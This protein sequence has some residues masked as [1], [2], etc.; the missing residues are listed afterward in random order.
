[1][2]RLHSNTR[3]A[4]LAQALPDLPLVRG[5][6]DRADSGPS[7]TAQRRDRP[8]PQGPGRLDGHGAQ[9]AAAAR[10]GEGADGAAAPWWGCAFGLR[11]PDIGETP[12][13]VEEV[14]HAVFIGVAMDDD[15]ELDTWP[16]KR[17]V[18]PAGTWT[19]AHAGRPPARPFDVKFLGSK[20]A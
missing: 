19:P 13:S 15:D 5:A 8:L 9:R 1:M 12:L 10:P 20:R 2:P 4:E 16:I 18:R 6:T 17:R 14:K 7:S 11:Q 3:S